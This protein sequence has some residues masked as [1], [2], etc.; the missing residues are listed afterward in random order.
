MSSNLK[1]KKIAVVLVTPVVELSHM[2]VVE[3]SQ[4]KTTVL[5]VVVVVLLQPRSDNP[6]PD[7]N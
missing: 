5:G 1:G 4:R 7:G 6:R 2:N 3:L